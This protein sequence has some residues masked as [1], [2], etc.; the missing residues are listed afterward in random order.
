MPV[1]LLDIVDEGLYLLALHCHN[2]ELL[3][4]GLHEDAELEAFDQALERS[5]LAVRESIEALDLAR[6][7]DEAEVFVRALRLN[8]VLPEDF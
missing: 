2:C 6:F 3:V 4:L 7:I 8:H 5:R 1:A